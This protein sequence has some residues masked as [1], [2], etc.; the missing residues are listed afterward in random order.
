MIWV[1]LIVGVILF[2]YFLSSNSKKVEKEKPILYDYKFT[3]KRFSDNNILEKCDNLSDSSKSC[4]KAY[5]H[6]KALNKSN[7]V[8]ADNL[9]DLKKKVENNFKEWAEEEKHSTLKPITTQIETH[10][11]K[12]KITTTFSKKELEEL[13][14]MTPPWDNYDFKFANM[15]EDERRDYYQ[16]YIAIDCETATSEQH[17]CQIGLAFME[18]GEIVD[19]KEYLIQPPNNKYDAINSRIHGIT[20]KDTKDAPSFADVWEE[21]KDYFNDSCVVAHNGMSADFIYLRKELKR[22]NLK[23]PINCIRKDSTNYFG[24]R[25]LKD[26]CAYYNIELINHHNALADARACAL[27]YKLRFEKGFQAPTADDMKEIREKRKLDENKRLDKAIKNADPNNF[28][29]QKGVLYTGFLGPDRNFVKEELLKRGAIIKQVVSRNVDIFIKGDEPGPS[30][31][32]K[33]KEFQD[34]GFD[35]LV[36]EK[37]EFYDKINS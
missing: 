18:K 30:K 4:Y 36:L 19:E 10:N 9:T 13:K 21:I 31:M 6:N 29:F 7:S 35:I 23:K 2:F 22:N 16:T 33:L 24:K 37:D 34:K 14:E 32:K 25:K 1:I 8:S 20:E 26:L 27:L 28:F 17:I 3:A 11:N 5:M 12:A 15:T